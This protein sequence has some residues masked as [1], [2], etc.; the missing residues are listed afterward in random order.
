VASLGW[1]CSY[2]ER[3]FK[4]GMRRGTWCPSFMPVIL[5]TW[6][7]E[8][9]RIV[10]QGQLEQIVHRDPISSITRAKWT[11]SVAQA[12]ECLLCKCEVLSLKA[13]SH[14]KGG[15]GNEGKVGS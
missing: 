8:I 11:G 7:A 9:W 12:L 6:E 3:F 4:K 2:K 13:Q 10:F 5:A 15:A 1:A 14:K